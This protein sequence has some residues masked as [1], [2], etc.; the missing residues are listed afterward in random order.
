MPYKNI[1]A[2]RECQ[3][4]NYHNNKD[5]KMEKQRE[6]REKNREREKIKTKEYNRVYYQK[7]HSYHTLRHWEESGLIETDQFKTS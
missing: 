1:E 4:R 6:Y 7:N 5:K 2:K 3:R